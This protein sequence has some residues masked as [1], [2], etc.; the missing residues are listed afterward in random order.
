M[1]S[2]KEINFKRLLTHSEALANVETLTKNAEDRWRFEKYVTHLKTQVESLKNEKIDE[3]A[4]SEYRRK[5]DFLST[6]LQ[7]EKLVL[8]QGGN[9]TQTLLH[10]QVLS[11][12]EKTSE[13][14][15]KLGIKT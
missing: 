10:S 7:P 6:L 3:T 9:A 1:P 14:E 4:M 13:Q 8:S 2:P 11:N 5:V 12:A 15:T